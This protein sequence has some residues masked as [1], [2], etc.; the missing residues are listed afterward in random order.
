M[1]QTL[2]ANVVEKL[3]SNDKKDMLEQNNLTIPNEQMMEKLKEIMGEKDAECF[4]QFAKDIEDVKIENSTILEFAGDFSDKIK[5]TAVHQYF[6]ASLKK[7]ESDTLSV[8]DSRK[9]RCFLKAG[10]S[11][12]KRMKNNIT[13]WSDKNALSGVQMPEYLSFALFKTNFESA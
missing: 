11:N 7:Y 8:G 9:I 13:N 5:R 10:F 6:K 3:E 12:N 4:L 1:R 2:P